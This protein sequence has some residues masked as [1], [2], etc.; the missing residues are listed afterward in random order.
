MKTLRRYSVTTRTIYPPLN[1]GRTRE[2]VTSGAA[3]SKHLCTQATTVPTSSTVT[4]FMQVAA[5][6]PAHNN[7]RRL[8]HLDRWHRQSWHVS[9]PPPH[10]S[11]TSIHNRKALSSHQQGKHGRIRLAGPHIMAQPLDR[12]GQ[13]QP[14]TYNRFFLFFYFGSHHP[15]STA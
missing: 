4:L 15:S 5:W 9:S 1:H 10:L 11:T 3:E 7:F 13:Q 6:L 14:A 8:R 2:R 12:S